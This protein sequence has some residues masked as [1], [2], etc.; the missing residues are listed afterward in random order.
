M[1]SA[2]SYDMKLT[3]SLR[4]KK[5][6]SACR[7]G[8]RA[9]FN[10]DRAQQQT[11]SYLL[12][13]ASFDTTLVFYFFSQRLL[14]TECHPCFLCFHLINTTKNEVNVTACF[15]FFPVLIDVFSSV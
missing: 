5:H 4:N 14:T 12:V 1:P 8:K 11:N 10:R 15:F 9:A 7:T 3:V 2:E 6:V 13:P